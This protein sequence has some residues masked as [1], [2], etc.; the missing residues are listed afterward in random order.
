[1]TRV[2]TNRGGENKREQRD[3][4]TRQTEHEGEG[5]FAS[6]EREKAGQE[7]KGNETE[8]KARG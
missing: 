2:G 8:I 5:R 6:D 1:M 4:G 3:R 7:G